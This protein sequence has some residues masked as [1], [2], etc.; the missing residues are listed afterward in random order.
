M[1][2]ILKLGSQKF[3]IE[4]VWYGTALFKDIVMKPPAG[5]AFA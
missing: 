2:K 3:Y 1:P 5:S 4:V